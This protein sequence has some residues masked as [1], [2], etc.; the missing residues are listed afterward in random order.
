[1]EAFLRLLSD[2]GHRLPDETATPVGD[3]VYRLPGADVAVFLEHDGAHRLTEQDENRM[4][5]DGWLV[6]RAGA[7][8]DWKD[9]VRAYPDV[10]GI[11]RDQAEARDDHRHRPRTR[12]SRPRT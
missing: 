6:I 9:T 12:H 4:M 5:D 3:V 8:P 11:G 1:M 10:F 2:G 7:E